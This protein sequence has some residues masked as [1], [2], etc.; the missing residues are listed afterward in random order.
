MK[1]DVTF[2]VYSDARWGDPDSMSPTLKKYHKFLWSKK[3]PNGDIF[4]LEE[5]SYVS[6]LVY[7]EWWEKKVFLGSDS[8]VH[9][10]GNHKRKKRLIDQ[11][12]RDEV[13]ELFMLG[14]TIAWYIIYPNNKIDAKHTINQA[15]WVNIMIDDRFDLTLEC[16]R[17]FYQGKNSPLYDTLLRYNDFFELFVDFKGYVEFFLLQDLLDEH[18]NIKFYLPF[19]NFATR[20]TFATVNDYFVYKQWVALFVKNRTTRILDYSKDF[21]TD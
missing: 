14:T 13:Q 9:H 19:D 3:L 7:D 2:D 6:Y 4:Q 5:K 16:I 21:M 12:S 10:Y 11:V 20:P 18:W 1:I 17:L 15:R 8:I